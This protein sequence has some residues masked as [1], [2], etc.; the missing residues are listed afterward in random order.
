MGLPGFRV[1]GDDQGLCRLLDERRPRCRA[2]PPFSGRCGWERRGH[3]ERQCILQQIVIF[4][5]VHQLVNTQR[6]AWTP[7]A[8]TQIT[9][10]CS[11]GNCLF[12]AIYCSIFRSRGRDLPETLGDIGL[13]AKA[14]W[15][16]SARNILLEGDGT[17]SRPT[18]G[19]NARDIMLD[20]GETADDYLALMSQNSPR[21]EA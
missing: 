5:D 15:I 16:R 9:R 6:H 17:A 12:V 1:I 21:P 10:I 18:S 2:V 14:F 20:G 8:D 19:I 7:N 3:Q 11:D 4:T 13:N